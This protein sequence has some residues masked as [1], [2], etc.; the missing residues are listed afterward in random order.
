MR[1][2]KNRV[3]NRHARKQAISDKE[4][5]KAIAEIENGLVDANYGGNLFKKRIARKGQ[6]KSG[7]HRAIP[8][9]VK[10]D[11]TFFMYGFEKSGKDNID[12]DEERDFKRLAKSYI[13]LDHGALMRARDENVLYEVKCDEKDL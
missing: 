12:K 9:Y 5:C 1:I 7:G 3:F 13:V 4:L 6:G 2:F 8:A 11:R 10:G